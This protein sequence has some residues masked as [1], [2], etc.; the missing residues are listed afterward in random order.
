MRDRTPP[1]RDATQCSAGVVADG[2]AWGMKSRL[3]S[4]CRCDPPGLK[5]RR[6]VTRAFDPEVLLG[7]RGEEH[8]AYL[9][10]GGGRL[11]EPVVSPEH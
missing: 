11:D 10:V 3:W 8:R 9:A 6:W 1:D 7:L 4:L 2:A 5:I